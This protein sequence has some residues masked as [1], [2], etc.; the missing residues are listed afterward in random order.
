MELLAVA[1]AASDQNR[2]SS[3]ESLITAVWQ[4]GVENDLIDA[5]VRPMFP[6]VR[7]V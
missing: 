6:R 5:R 1:A 7:S 3:F 4:A 2:E